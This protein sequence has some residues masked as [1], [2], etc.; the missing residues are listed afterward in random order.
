MFSVLTRF[1]RQSK[2]TPPT[3]ALG[4]LLMRLKYDPA[5]RLML[6]G[7]SAA[8]FSRRL[9]KLRAMPENN[10]TQLEA[11]IAAVAEFSTICRLGRCVL[12]RDLARLEGLRGDDL[13]QAIYLLRIMRVQGVDRAGD[14]PTVLGILGKHGF[15]ADAKVVEAMFIDDPNRETRCTALLECADQDF[16]S[17]PAIPEDGWARLVDQRGER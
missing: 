12:W 11:K 15:S 2:Q 10:G 14:L 5:A 16:R 9:G 17:V 3:S 6:Q 1:Y 4:Q 13:L 7:M 8:S